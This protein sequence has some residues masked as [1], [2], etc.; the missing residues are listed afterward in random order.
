VRYLELSVAV[1]PNAVEA[2]AELM[3]RHV[4]SGVSIEPPFTPTE[5][6]GGVALDDGPVRLR[7]WLP[8][9]ARRDAEALRR[10]LRALGDAVARPLRVRAVEGERWAETWKR[11]FTTI[12]VGRRLVIKPSWRTHAAR[13]DDVVIELD[14]GAA[15]GTGQHETTRMCLEALEARVAPGDRILD[16]GCGSGILAIAA[17]KLRAGHVDAIDIDA[18]AVAATE[19]N[20]ERNRVDD[21]VR[22]AESSLDGA[23]LFRS[24]VAGGYDL[25]VA[26][27]SS[28]LVQELAGP[29]LAALR[30]GGV[31]LV[32][33][34]I[35]EQEPACREALEAAGGEVVESRAEGDWRLLAVATAQPPR[36]SR[37]SGRQARRAP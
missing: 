10:E 5:A 35:G 24:R 12:R 21:I 6:E 26:N 17:A 30:R 18:A 14:P 29:V 27:L 15:F 37:A 16:L 1:H 25:V 7:A 2:A 13:H 33:G 31:A 36:T 19:Q 4:P 3:R 8:E 9:H 22:A 23:W 20:A 11:H 32:S 28:R 34:L